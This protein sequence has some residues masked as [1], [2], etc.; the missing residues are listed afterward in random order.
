MKTER[1]NKN[2]SLE[3]MLR[4]W[5]VRQAMEQVPRQAYGMRRQKML[6]MVGRW[7]PLAAAAVLVMVAGGLFYA[8][9]QR[10]ENA[11]Y[12]QGAAAEDREGHFRQMP[13]RGDLEKMTAEVVSLSEQLAK[14]RTTGDEQ[15]AEMEFLEG[16]LAVAQQ[17]LEAANAVL[18]EVGKERDV[19]KQEL[20]AER[21]RAE[22]AESALAEAETAESHPPTAEMAELYLS[23]AAPGWSGMSAVQAAAQNRRLSAR[24]G[25]L[26]QETED[27][28]M[29]YLLDRLEAVLTRLAMLDVRDEHSVAV[30]ASLT[31]AG[32]LR[33][34]LVEA[35]AAAGGS[36]MGQFLLEVQLI[37]RGVDREA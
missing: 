12:V 17:E 35:L 4:Q 28:E 24:C 34:Q 23:L 5:G 8:S 31:R 29:G 10:N 13:A 27:P 2:D 22:Q 15:A 6:A 36:E 14:L 3:G 21:V 11:G 37:F 19:A 33:G 30:F 7:A 16:Q 25:Q 20:L 32:Q 26:R 18:A 9:G 1:N